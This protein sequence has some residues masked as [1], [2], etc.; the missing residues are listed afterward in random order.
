MPP[1]KV[2]PGEV[3]D[4]GEQS[5]EWP[6]FVFVI[7]GA[8]ARGWIPSRILR[9]QGKTGLVIEGYDTTTLDPEVGEELAII[10]E[11]LEGGWVWCRDSL[12]RVGW[13]PR[14]HLQVGEA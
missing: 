9:I 4:V 11:D 3:L 13:F 7:K 12:S 5:D 8:R 1:L 6:A 10:E 2:A 14:N